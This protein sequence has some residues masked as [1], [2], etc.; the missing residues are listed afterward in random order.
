[1][2]PDDSLAD[3]MYKWEK[4]ARTNKSQKELKFTFKVF[5]FYMYMDLFCTDPCDFK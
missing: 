3:A 4:W 2:M 5:I 1:M